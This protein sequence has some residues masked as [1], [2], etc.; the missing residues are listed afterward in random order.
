V[1]A[2]KVRFHI[3]LFGRWYSF[4]WQEKYYSLDIN[5]LRLFTKNNIMPI[6]LNVNMKI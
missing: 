4:T 5:E 6:L 2:I 1:G 3:G